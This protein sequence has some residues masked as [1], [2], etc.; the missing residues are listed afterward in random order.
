MSCHHVLQPTRR[1]CNG[2]GR[3]EKISQHLNEIGVLHGPVSWILKGGDRV[4]T[5]APSDHIDQIEEATAKIAAFRAE[6][7][8]TRNSSVE[9]SRSPSETLAAKSRERETTAHLKLLRKHHGTFG[10]VSVTSGYRVDPSTG[11][12]IDWGLVRMPAASLAA[13]ICMFP[14]AGW[15]GQTQK[16]ILTVG[17]P[18]PGEEVCKL[19]RSTNFTSGI[20]SP[21]L[22][23]VDLG[24]NGVITTEWAIIG[25]RN[26][27]FSADGDSGSW[28]INKEYEVVGMIVGNSG[29]VSYMTP[30]KAVIK[31]IEAVTGKAVILHGNQGQ[32]WGKAKY[33][34]PRSFFGLL[35]ASSR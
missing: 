19:G 22:H 21:A 6:R 4:V 32:I 7:T 12:S 25:D 31:D 27:P 33:W 20:V 14:L 23:A 28:V 29:L 2:E 17:D 18:I 13:N 8:S 16:V 26:L 10:K 11:F 35:K 9:L 24:R 3:M 15:G 30:I 5:P 34:K 1:E